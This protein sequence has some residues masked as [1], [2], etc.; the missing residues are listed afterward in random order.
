MQNRLMTRLLLTFFTVL[1]AGF[2][3]EARAEGISGTVRDAKTSEPLEGV[4]VL[5]KGTTR[6]ANTDSEGRYNIRNID[7]GD[8]ILVVSALAYTTVEIECRIKEQDNVVDVYLESEDVE[9]DE[10]VVRARLRNNTETAIVQTVKSVAQVASGISAAQISRSPDRVASE[11][12]RRVPGVTVIDDRLIVVRG[13]AQRYNNAWINGMAAP[14]VE[15][16]SRA[17]PFD[18]IPSSQ[19]DNLMI[20]KSPSPEIPGDFSGGFIKIT[21]KSVP[22]ENRFEASY[23]TGFNTM[24]HFDGFRIGNGSDTDFLGFD[25]GRRSLSGDFPEHLENVTDPGEITRLTKEGFNR[26]WTVRN[27]RPLPDQR[28]TLTAVR[29][30]ETKNNRIIGN[31]TSLNYSN[32]FKG[33]QR[34]KN[35]RYDVYNYTEDHPVYL[36]NYED[37]QFSNNAS[38]VSALTQK[39]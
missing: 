32:V 4:T 11:V 3:V 1:S 15:T 33:V 35:V 13:L 5:I 7:A 14:S 16:D 10:V 23:A 9:M 19:I 28:L 8:C 27:I 18:L 6:G 20:Y 12:M 21:S 36:D 22:D 2:F 29:R 26:D 24:T 17:F 38:T 34:M 37:N 39:L 30:I 25:D 31:L